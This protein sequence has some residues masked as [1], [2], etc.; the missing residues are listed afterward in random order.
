MIYLVGSK[1]MLLTGVSVEDME[2]Q[3]KKRQS[4]KPVLAKN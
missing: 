3:T 1:W 4:L 2:N